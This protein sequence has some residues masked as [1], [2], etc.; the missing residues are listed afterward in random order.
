MSDARRVYVPSVVIAVV[1]VA[2]VPGSISWMACRADYMIILATRKAGKRVPEDRPK[3]TLSLA[4]IQGLGLIC[5]RSDAARSS[6]GTLSWTT[7]LEHDTITS[8]MAV[9]I[10]IP[11]KEEDPVD[12]YKATE[13]AT[14]LEYDLY[15]EIVR[16]RFVLRFW[17]WLL[18]LFV[19]LLSI[20]TGFLVQRA[21]S[22][23][24]IKGKPS[25]DTKIEIPNN[26]SGR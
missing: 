11:S 2:K 17:P 22:C 6:F 26:D 5:K 15:P 7:A 23:S 21:S 1:D 16:R 18:H 20:S 25:A 4:V 9:Y 14:P 24:P 19:F 13:S 12:T 8:V 3:I 10:A